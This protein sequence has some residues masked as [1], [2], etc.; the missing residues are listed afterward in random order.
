MLPDYAVMVEVAWLILRL[1][2]SAIGEIAPAYVAIAASNRVKHM[3]NVNP[4]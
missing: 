3:C 1:F 4:Q 2:I